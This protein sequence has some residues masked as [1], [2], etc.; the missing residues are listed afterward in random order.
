MDPVFRREE[1]FSLIELLIVVAIL[2]ILA[3]IAIPSLLS[4]HM[5]ANEASAVDSLKAITGA[6]TS[7]NSTYPDVG[8]ANTLS[9]LATPSGGGA[10]TPSAAGYLDPVLACN[11]QPCTKSG[12]MFSIINATGTPVSAYEV[13]GVPASSVSGIRG[14]CADQEGTIT[15]DPAGGTN[16]IT[17]L[18]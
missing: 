2:L 7:Y 4:S 14:F 10:P 11:N 12:Y 9:A 1:G 13:V 8:F 6:Q 17:P 15:F 18:Q 16:C 3:A 5:A